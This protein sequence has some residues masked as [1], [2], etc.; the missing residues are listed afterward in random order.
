MFLLLASASPTLPF[1]DPVL[2]VALAMTIFLV[3]PL[4]FERLRVPGI[5]G[6]I[7][8]GAAV[9]PN[10]FGLLARDPTIVLLGTVGLLYLMLMVGLELDLNEFSRYRNRSIVFGT[11]SFVIPAAAGVGMGLA[12]EY[13]LLSSLLLGS[14]FSSHTLL[15]YPIASRLGIVR[16]P[17]V[18][19]TLGGTI[20]TEVLAL[21][22]LAVVANA[23]G[24]SL[25]ARF[26]A[27]LAIPFALY[28]GLVLW[29]L[30][31]LGRW[32]F[33][34]V[35]NE[36]ATE[37]VFV[38]VALFTVSYLAHAAG[39][40]PI[41]GALLVGL[42]LNRLIP[43][44]SP[45]M[46][47]IHFA[48]NALFIPF[49][50][51]SVGMLV[52]VRA[53]DTPRAWTIALA[54]AGGVTLS[55][56]VASKA[57]EKLFGY[58]AEEGWVVFGL[59]VPHAAG[60]L[61][62]V[63]VG[64]EVGLLDQTEVNGVV[65]MILVTC[66]VGPWATERY[67]RR[68]ALQEEHRPYDPLGAPRRVLIPLANP[69]TA[70]ALLDL[71]FVVRGAG[72]SE[73][74]HPLMVVGGSGDRTEAEVAEAERT[75]AHAVLYAAGAAVPV[76][77][78]TRV[79]HNVATGIARGIAET[80]SSTVVVGWD[81]R[82]SAAREIFG[83]VLDQ[84]L[85]ETRQLVLVARLGH[86]LNT[87]RRVVL[88]LPPAIE[89][90]PGFLEAVRTVKAVAAGVGAPVRALVVKTDPE[91]LREPYASAGGQLPT[92]WE[93]LADWSALRPEL[94]GT[95]QR[96]DLVVVVGARRGTLP[97]NPRLERLPVLLA[98]LVPESFI[99][100][101]P[102]EAEPGGDGASS[103]ELIPHRVV[104]LGRLPLETALREML[105]SCFDDP[106]RVREILRALPPG[107][108]AAGTEIAPGVVVPH[109]RVNGM[110]EPI[111]LLGVSREGVELPGGR[112]P[113]HLV[114]LL[115]SAADRP[116]EHL[117]SLAEIARLVR[118]PQN[119]SEMIARHAPDTPLDWLHVDP[120]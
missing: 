21:L 23:T 111:L 20:L 96:D 84:L 110:E 57:A 71:A 12:L 61:A 75:L 89:R 60:T 5:I 106:A 31:R 85:E 56:W 3:V 39:V 13:S 22:L 76:V 114:F 73:P 53:L 52:D 37:F 18:T 36:A 34:N 14:A 50:L 24:G 105:A 120:H 117:R 46:N 69:A 119:M 8:V 70:D 28:V 7:V 47:R 109:A 40:E 90:H 81:G 11:L 63:L 94:E 2:I 80:R 86:P 77:P 97:W 88:V 25:G 78:L 6:L 29:G 15:A 66:L 92:T 72:N 116:T 103:G 113:A 55:K 42:A 104:P 98:G 108:Q 54:L 93:R 101:Y 33:R 30:P 112:P 38:M 35:G 41:I 74:I 65:L 10:G 82:R 83:S 102:P 79:D 32:F 62:I 48:G 1:T 87:T 4:L 95:L 68:V 49:F 9:G 45:L 51:L 67:G 99:I 43:A 58:S 16:N 107:D 59:S 100:L 91:R 17:A 27:A 26:W 64:Y 44:Q 19:T 115:V 118:R